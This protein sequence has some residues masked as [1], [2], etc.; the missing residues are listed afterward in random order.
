MKEKRNSFS[1]YERLTGKIATEMLFTSGES[2]FSYPFLVLYTIVD[3]NAAAPAR[4][5][6]SASKKK[7][8]RAVHRNLVKRRMREVY[9]LKKNTFYDQ[10]GDHHIHLG[11]IYVGKDILEYDAMD[12]R[13]DKVL[14]GVIERLNA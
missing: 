6:I 9:R 14:R 10:L 4:L 1:K 7:F 3:L 12:K 5:L 11:L 13:M 8:K 2:F